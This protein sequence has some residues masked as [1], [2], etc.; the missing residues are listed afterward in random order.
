MDTIKNFI[1]NHSAA[2]HVAAVVFAF[3]FGAYFQVPAFHDYVNG[4]YGMFPQGIKQLVAT[5]V[6]L[7]MW[8]RNGEPKAA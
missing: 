6:A 4:I 8:Y 7:Y 1:A 5:G 3:L 2:T